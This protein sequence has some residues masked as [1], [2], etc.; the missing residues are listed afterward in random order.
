MAVQLLLSGMSRKFLKGSAGVY[1]AV[2]EILLK[3]N[4]GYLYKI[5]ESEINGKSRRRTVTSPK[6]WKKN[7]TGPRH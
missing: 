1:S 7:F 2:L 6:E 5:L 3:N 4:D